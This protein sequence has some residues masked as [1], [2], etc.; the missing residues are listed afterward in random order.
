MKLLLA[1]ILSLSMLSAGLAQAA[2]DDCRSL[3]PAFPE[4]VASFKQKR[5][6]CYHFLSEPPY[7]EERKRFLEAKIKETCVGLK[8]LSR[9][10]RTKYVGQSR[11]LNVLEVDETV[12]Y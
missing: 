8:E 9:G 12:N 10:L 11:I 7:D 1:T 2:H 4:D 5:C 3:D 6:V